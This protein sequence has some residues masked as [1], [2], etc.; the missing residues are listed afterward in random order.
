MN[1]LLQAANPGLA[2]R[3]PIEDAFAF[4]SFTMEQLEKVLDSKMKK[5]G[6][7]ATS[8][9]HAVAFDV[10]KLTRM[11][12]NFCNGGGIE[13]VLSKAKT[14]FQQRMSA[15]MKAGR[16]NEVIFEPE[17]FDPDHERSTKTVNEIDQLFAEFLGKTS[18]ASNFKRYARIAKA[19]TTKGKDPKDYIPFTF[20]FKGPPGTAKTTTA[21]KIGQIHYILDCLL[22]PRWS[23]RRPGTCKPYTPISPRKRPE[24]SSRARL[25]KCCLLT[26][27]T[28]LGARLRPSLATNPWT[29]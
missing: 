19:I 2:R 9:A 15:I 7:G 14:N 21:R 10:L 28:R 13:N 17:D 24:T 8:K 5:Q 26:K 16:P 1:A 20:V 3:F 6:L 27:R 4:E 12:S 25:A 29:A 23:R 22:S 18:P 11:C